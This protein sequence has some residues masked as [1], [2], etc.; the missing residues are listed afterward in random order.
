MS[1]RVPRRAGSSWM[2]GVL[3]SVALVAVGCSGGLP[4]V[5]QTAA[6]P[7]APSS[8]V[9]QVTPQPHQISRLGD[10]VTVQGRVELV[11]DPLVD[12]PTRDLA[13]QVLRAAGASEVLVRQPGPPAPDVT[14]QVRLGDRESP[15]LVKTL[16]DLS[17]PAP[18][19]LPPEGYVLVARG[20]SDQTVALGANDPS[21]AYYAVQTLRQ[22]VTPG[23]I[24]GVGVVDYPLMSTRGTVEGFY[25]SPWTQQQRMD[26]LAFYGDMK[27]DT[28]VY[29]PKDDPYLRQ[30]WRDPYPP[31]KL[32]EVRQ[33]IGQAAAHHVH[34][35]YALSPGIS[36]C[37]SNPADV[38]ALQAKFQAMYNVG[39]RDFS[40]PFD[41]ITY[42]QWN[43]PQDH[44]VYGPPSESA[45]GRAQADLLNAVQRNF[46]A[47]H[48][49]V[50]ALQTVPTE[51]S[52]VDDS[53]YKAALRTQLDPNVRV[54]WTGDGVV[55]GAITI[56]QAQQAGAIWGRKPMLWDNFP[57]DDFPGSV[58]RLL[59]GPYAQRQPGLDGQ[60]TGDVVNPMNQAAASEVA[61]TGAA[62]FSWND[63]AFDPQRAW[64]AAAA[65]LT[66]GGRPGATPDPATVNSLL[67]F[68]DL[69]HMAPLPSGRPWQVPAPELNNRL[70][71]FRTAFNGGDRARALS[72][73][74]GYAQ[75]IADAPARIRAGAA[76]AFASDAGPW[77]DATALWGQSLLAT[78][79]G[80][81][82]RVN[83]DEPGAN[84]R[85]AMAAGLAQ[86]ASA[87]RTIPGVTKPQ[88]PVFVADGVLD[89]FIRQ[90]PT[91]R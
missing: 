80:L 53:A 46:V 64:Q 58:G 2:L 9:P 19:P 43:C 69:E 28:Y 36:I 5:A 65:Y 33:L 60:L 91:L 50:S 20:G 42:T 44:A 16:Q 13:V 82:S 76:P 90:A 21:G 59:L 3:L 7:S 35:T 57:V 23:R 32:G 37:F 86:R 81:Q 61:E 70:G 26:Q 34:F 11:V 84:Q 83:G 41:D 62:D 48:P 24:A 72:D 14:L 74:R 54:M 31:D 67:V 10:D 25:G 78:V 38:S 79:D 27:L 4:P 17:F 89:V 52:D 87:I 30:Q 56:P 39:V 29:S 71:A 49:D 55:P 18:E 8:G 77:L 47:S 75:Q 85:F 12:Q 40:V 45:A 68:F 66:D 15:S 1:L 73:L 88:G 6:Q 22:L 51:Y 63:A